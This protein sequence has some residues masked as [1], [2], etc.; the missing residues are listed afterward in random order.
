[1]IRTITIWYGGRS[2]REQRLLLFMLALLLLVFLW[3]LIVR[4]LNDALAEARERH[5]A[6]VLERAEARA[7][8]EAL[9]TLRRSGGA[10]LTQ[11]VETIVS[12]SAGQA[13]FQLSRLRAEPGGAVSIGIEAAR[14]QAFFGW[15]SSLEQKGL[16]VSTLS[17]TANADRTLAVQA[18][19]RGRGQ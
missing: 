10:A 6:A 5:D 14:P 9:G 4:P 16:I 12:Q 18:S 17:A 3:L 2:V 15:I 13:G 19:F 7:Q 1:M 11:P 8:A